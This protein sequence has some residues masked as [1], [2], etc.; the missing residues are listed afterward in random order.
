M[1]GGDPEAPK[2]NQPKEWAE[3]RDVAAKCCEKLRL[4][5]PCVI[6][7]MQNSTDDAYAGWPDRMFIVAADGRIA[8]AGRLG[9]WGFKPGE[10]ERWLLKNVGSPRTSVSQ[11]ASPQTETAPP[12]DAPPPPR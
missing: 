12:G 10:V 6:D 2:L 7:D 11:P 4:S 3:R 5:L 8:Y 1:D 9:P